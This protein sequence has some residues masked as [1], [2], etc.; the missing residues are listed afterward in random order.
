[1]KLTESCINL[2][3]K[4]KKTSTVLLVAFCCAEVLYGVL[5]AKSKEAKIKP[6]SIDMTR[7]E[8]VEPEVKKA[9]REEV[10]AMLAYLFF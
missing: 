4:I 5:W 9:S 1:L 2:F 8:E 10:E 3:L 7:G 6:R